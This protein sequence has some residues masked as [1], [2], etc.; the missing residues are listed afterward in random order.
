MGFVVLFSVAWIAVFVLKGMAKSLTVLEN[1][2]IFLVVMTISINVSWILIDEL[3]YI[4]AA[5]NGLKY[6]AYLI[7]RSMLVPLVFVIA[8]NYMY[9]FES[10][11]AKWLT[12]AIWAIVV[13]GI[14]A[15]EQW[16]R[17]LQYR[18]W[19]Y[20]YDAIYVLLLEAIAYYVLK[21]FRKWT[22]AEVGHV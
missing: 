16:F 2:L 7:C 6:A 22:Y 14:H 11:A 3:H 15:I 12:V 13:L 8:T 18:Q 21:L 5:Q 19:N 17:I 10:A 20:A 1:A 4:Q 9:R